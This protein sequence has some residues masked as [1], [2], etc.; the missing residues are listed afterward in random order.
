VYASL[1]ISTM[2]FAEMTRE[3]PDAILM[4]SDA[5]TM[6]NRRRVVE[7]AQG[8]PLA[9]NLRGWRARPRRRPDV[10]RPRQSA[11]GES[12]AELVAR[13]LRGAPACGP[14]ARIA[15]RFEFSSI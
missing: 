7:F 4:V 9:D 11:I 2:V 8:Q 14:A 12:A 15:T 5:L 10:V 1:T 13:I 6:L 3:R